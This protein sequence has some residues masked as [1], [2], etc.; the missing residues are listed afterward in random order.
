L[1]RSKPF[2][3]NESIYSVKGLKLFEED[4]EIINKYFAKNLFGVSM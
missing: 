3:R 1:R 4:R 2:Y